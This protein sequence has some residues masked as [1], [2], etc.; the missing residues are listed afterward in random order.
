M[1]RAQAGKLA[2]Y[3]VKALLSLPRFFCV[4]VSAL[5]VEALSPDRDHA[6]TLPEQIHN[7][8]ILIFDPPT[9]LTH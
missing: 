6:Q 7:A 8:P 1:P 2:E 5:L 4:I 9:P 3:E